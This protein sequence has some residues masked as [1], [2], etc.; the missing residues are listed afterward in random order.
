[1]EG[2][3]EFDP[4]TAKR[5]TDSEF[6]VDVTTGSRYAQGR[7]ANEER[8][9]ELFQLGVYGI[10]EVVNALNISDKQDVIQ[11]W[12]VRN[13]QVPPQQQ[14]QQAEDMQ[15]QLGQLVAQV[16]QEGPGGPGEEALAQM[17]I[18]NPALAE[19][20]DFQQLPGE[21]QE[22]IITVAGLVGGQGEDSEMDQPRA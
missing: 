2:T 8:A 17:I 3:P 9:L 15:Q 7:V 18:A 19:S 14:I 20:P 10:E 12:Y 4:G 22:R 16:L 21:V 6:D 1:M 5:L 13:Q 11:N